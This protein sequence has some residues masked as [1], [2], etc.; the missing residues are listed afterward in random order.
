M[1][2]GMRPSNARVCHFTTRAGWTIES[3]DFSSY[4]KVEVTECREPFGKGRTPLTQALRVGLLSRFKPLSPMSTQ[5]ISIGASGISVLLGLWFLGSSFGNQGLQR[6]LQKKQDDIQAQ[7]QELQSQQQ[8]IDAGSQLAQQV[9]PAMIRDLAAL[10][11][12]KNNKKIAQLLLKYGIEAKANPAPANA[13]APPPAP[14]AAP[15]PKPQNGGQ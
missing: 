10:Q 4:C 1:P 8:L 5:L 14:P 2:C 6:T 9:G 12:D 11:L 3:M 13:P 15:N 7:Q